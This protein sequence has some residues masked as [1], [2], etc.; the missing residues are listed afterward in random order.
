[1]DFKTAWE[2]NIKGCDD[3]LVM[4]VVGTREESGVLCATYLPPLNNVM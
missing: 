4:S 3:Q 2:F 1:M